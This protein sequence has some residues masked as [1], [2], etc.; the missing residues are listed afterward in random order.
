VAHEVNKGHE[1]NRS[2]ILTD[3]HTVTPEDVG[4]FL[5]LT[6]LG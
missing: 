2:W 5:K 6:A 3:D 1:G 4:G